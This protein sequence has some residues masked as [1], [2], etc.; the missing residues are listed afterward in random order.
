MPLLDAHGLTV[1]Y[2][3][4]HA[5]DGIDLECEAGKIVG[6]IGP[7]GA[8]KTTFIDA[9]TGFAPVTSGRVTFDGHDLHRLSPSARARLGLTR[10]FQSMELFDDLSVRDNLLVSAERLHWWSFFSDVVH[11]GRRRADAIARIDWALDVMDLRGVVDT[12]PDQLSHGQRKLVAMA[13]AFA[14]R[15][16]L[17]L[18]DEPAAGLDSAESQALGALLA[19]VIDE[20]ISLFVI[21]HDM[22]LMLTVCDDMY[23][24]D[25]GRIIA[26]GTPEAIR[27]DPAVIAAYL[28]SSKAPEPQLFPPPE[29]DR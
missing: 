16:K 24:L 27:D 29:H 20:G 4:V 15:P 23:V 1:S 19:S 3:G 14:A 21:D 12:M 5:N 10:T 6:L 26:H 17:V 28:G 2:G 11:P 7:N 22:A 18:L 8:G 9:I 13:R 25:F